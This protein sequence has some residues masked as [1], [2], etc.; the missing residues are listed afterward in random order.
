MP[1]WKNQNTGVFLDQTNLETPA[2]FR[3]NRPGRNLTLVGERNAPTAP[4]ANQALEQ[5]AATLKAKERDLQAALA[6]I[7]VGLGA[8]SQRLLT[9]MALIA[10]TGI[11][12]WS[13]V[14]PTGWRFGTAIAFA[15][16]VLLPLSYFDWSSRRS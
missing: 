3:A 7:Q 5:K 16:L 4:A 10:T 13:V 11:F 9:V 2:V 14:E 6:V 1:S 8:L 15:V 12:S